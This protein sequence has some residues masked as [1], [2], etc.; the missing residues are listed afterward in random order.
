MIDY[1]NMDWP[2]CKECGE[3]FHPLR[4][5]SRHRQTRQAHGFFGIHRAT[6][7]GQQQVFLRINELQNVGERILIAAEIGAAQG[8]GHH[9]GTTGL[10]GVAH[11]LGRREFPRAQN[12]ARSKLAIGN[13]QRRHSHVA[14]VRRTPASVEAVLIFPRSRAGFG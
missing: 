9:L 10:K 2:E 8:D 12:Q 4:Q 11:Q 13:L 7:V 14:K 5:S 3:E 1:D 6:G